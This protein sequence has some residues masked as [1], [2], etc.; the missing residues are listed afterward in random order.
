MCQRFSDGLAF[1]SQQDWTTDIGGEGPRLERSLVLSSK[2][3]RRKGLI[4][5]ADLLKMVVSSEIKEIP[6][7]YRPED[8][9]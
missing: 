3:P 9:P 7:G 8:L 6:F 4:K 1:A 5:N 2:R